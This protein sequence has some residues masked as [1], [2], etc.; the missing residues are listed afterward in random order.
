MDDYLLLCVGGL[1]NEASRV[2][3]EA[4]GRED[5]EVHANASKNVH[6][7]PLTNSENV[8]MG[9]AGLGKL[10]LRTVS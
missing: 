2:V 3:E 4:L 9:H 7:R 10:H 8:Q 6:I 5:W 1:E